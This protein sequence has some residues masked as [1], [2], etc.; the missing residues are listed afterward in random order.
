[1]AAVL[2]TATLAQG[3]TQKPVTGADRKKTTAPAASKAPVTTDTPAEAQGVVT[4]PTTAQP[5]ATT[6]Q[7][8]TTSTQPVTTAPDEP[9]TPQSSA[10]G[11]TGN[12]PGQAQTSPGEASDITP[13]QTGTTPSGQTTGAA[14]AAAL[15]A[16]TAADVKAGV[17]VFDQKGGSVGK[18]ESVTGERAVVDTGKVK[19][20]VPI[21]SFAKNDQ[22]LVISMTKAEIDAAAKPTTKAAKK[23]K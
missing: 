5:A 9:A 13:A 21:S 1:L 11:Q 3:I 4:S 2:S 22:G 18:V 15:T 16:A 12:T 17:S 20:T 6:T 10:P 19:A 8:V 23:P 14:P 7:P